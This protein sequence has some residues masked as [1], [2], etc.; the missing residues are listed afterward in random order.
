M[1]IIAYLLI[2]AEVGREYD[3]A[4]RIRG[5]EGVTEARIVY[6]EFDIV[7]RLEV[8]DLSVLDGIVTRMRGIPGIIKT[9]TLIASP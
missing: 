8:P 4:N 7:A 9:S 6:G 2:V 5:M 3:I 1:P